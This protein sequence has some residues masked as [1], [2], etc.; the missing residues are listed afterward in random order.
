MIANELLDKCKIRRKICN[1]T[2]CSD[3][4]FIAVYQGLLGD[5]LKG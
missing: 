3:A 1:L 4:F 5:D 2:E